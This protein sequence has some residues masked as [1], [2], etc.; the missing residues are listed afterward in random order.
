MKFTKR[1]QMLHLPEIW[2]IIK[3]YLPRHQWISLDEI[4]NIVQ[5]HCNLDD[6]DFEAQSPSSDIP[7]WKRNV[8]MCCSIVRERVK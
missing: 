1:I 5:M 2:S 8:R 6:E 3:T 4:Y 7:K